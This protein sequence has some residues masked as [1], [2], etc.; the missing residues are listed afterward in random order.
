MSDETV[1]IRKTPPSF[2]YL[3]RVNGLR[4]GESIMLREEG[5]TVGRSATV[6]IALDDLTVS[7]EHA[8]F[9]FEDGSWYAYDLG[10]SN[11]VEVEGEA[12]QRRV[13]SDKDRI[14]IGLAEFVFRQVR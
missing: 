12:I 3:F 1:I 4:R 13:L 9:R 11:P 2:A 10:A 5:V 8:R 6:D 7:A 14:R